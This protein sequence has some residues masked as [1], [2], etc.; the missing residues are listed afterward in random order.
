MP[1]GTFRLEYLSN[2]LDHNFNCFVE[3]DD[4]DAPQVTFNA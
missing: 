4:K 2:F 3:V 1:T